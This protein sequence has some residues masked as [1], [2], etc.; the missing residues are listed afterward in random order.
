LD[1]WTYPEDHR[2]ILRDFSDRRQ[3]LVVNGGYQLLNRSRLLAGRVATF[4]RGESLDQS[5]IE[6]AAPKFV[7]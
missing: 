5:A 7:F 2:D 1:G 4:M 3:I 6:L